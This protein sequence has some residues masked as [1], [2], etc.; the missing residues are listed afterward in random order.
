MTGPLSLPHGQFV[1]PGNRWDLLDG[2]RPHRSPSVSVVVPYFDAQPQL[3]RV[4]GALRLQ[5]FPLDRL[6]IVV[7]DDGSPDP[8]SLAAAGDLDVVLVQQEDQG[9]RAAAARN[10]GVRHS[11]GDVLCFL[12]ADTVPEPDYIA[13]L[14]RLPALCP[15]ALVTGRR[16]HAD[17]DGWSPHHV[18]GWL[19]G[20]SPPPVELVE[21]EWLR[22][23]HVQTGNLSQLDDSSYQAVLSAVLACSRRLFEEIH[24]F[25]ESMIGYGGEDWEL[26]HRAL[27][28]GAVL[29]H[30]PSAVAWHDGPDWALRQDENTR[31]TTKAAETAALARRMPQPGTRSV[32]PNVVVIADE[33][34]DEAV[35]DALRRAETDCRVWAR[36]VGSHGPD[37]GS[38]PAE[39]LTSA[40]VVVEV[41]GPDSW[42]SLDLPSLVDR[43]GPPG[44]GRVTLRSGPSTVTVTSTRALGRSRRW[45]GVLD[46][47]D[48]LDDLFGTAEIVCAP[49]DVPR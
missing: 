36:G 15:D 47:P 17:L 28:A 19:T 4:L 32:R 14:T 7:V 33:D 8:P 49:A 38:P 11:T 25:D 20:Q 44:P 48:L 12:D 9:F 22:R 39:V 34:V 29:A 43:V 45:A 31:R 2:R 10:L 5:T 3:D 23:I 30:V 46:R 1:V 26:A 27:C 37:G 41:S 24:G 35:L 42:P 40:R 13:E 18:R 6:Q 21:P 16:R